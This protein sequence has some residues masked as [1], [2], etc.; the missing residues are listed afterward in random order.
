MFV[1]VVHNSTPYFILRSPYISPFFALQYL[2]MN[3]YRALILPSVTTLQSEP[4]PFTMHVT[5]L[6]EKKRSVGILRAMFAIRPV[7]TSF[8]PVL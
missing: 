3:H 2:Q 1:Q 6:Q 8:I 7:L 4:F 5:Y